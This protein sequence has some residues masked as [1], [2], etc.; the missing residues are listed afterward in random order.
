MTAVQDWQPEPA[1]W[2]FRMLAAHL[3]AVEQSCYLSRVLRIASG[4]RPQIS[5]YSHC[6]TP[7]PQAHLRESLRQWIATRRRLIDVVELLN[8]QQLSYVGIHAV[9]GPVTLLDTLAD[10]VAQD[11]GNLRHIRQLILAYEEA[12]SGLPNSLPSRITH[13]AAL[14]EAM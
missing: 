9:L 8:H 12:A 11:Q 7:A 1:E 14:Y 6:V 4:T 3:A 5:L 10:L 2:S 13:P